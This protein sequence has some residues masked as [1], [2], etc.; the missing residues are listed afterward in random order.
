MGMRRRAAAARE[1]FRAA[2]REDASG[3]QPDKIR[4]LAADR[5]QSAARLA[6]SRWIADQQRFGIGVAPPMEDVMQHATLDDLAG[7]EADD[8]VAQFRDEYQTVREQED[9]ALR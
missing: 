6:Q 3:R 4:D 8:V 9:R 5:W 1:R 2:R 7:I